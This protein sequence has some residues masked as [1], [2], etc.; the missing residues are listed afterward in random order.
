MSGRQLAVILAVAGCSTAPRTAAPPAVDIPRLRGAPGA[1]GSASPREP[2]ATSAELD[3]G[4]IEFCA[5]LGLC[6]LA[7]T[8]CRAVTDDDCADSRICWRHGQCTAKNG[9]C[10]AGSDADCRRAELCAELGK[11]SARGGECAAV[12]DADCRGAAV[13]EQN[14]ACLADGGDCVP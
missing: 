3:C 13:C 6:T 14:G 8:E 11:C 10:V 5:Q 4:R 2:G 12:T 7:G 1:R 9:G